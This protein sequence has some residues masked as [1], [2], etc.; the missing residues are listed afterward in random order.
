MNRNDEIDK[1]VESIMRE[2]T[3]NPRDY[4]FN[5]IVSRYPKTSHETF[6]FPGKF[7]KSLDRIV[8]KEDG[9]KLELDIAE[10]VEKDGFIT[11]KSTINVEHQTTPIEYGKIDP[12]YDYKIHL[13]H[14]NNLPSISIVITPIEQDEK[15]K[16]YTSKNNV[17]NVYHIVVREKD[18]CEKLNILRNIDMNIEISESN[19]INFAYIALFVTGDIDKKILEEICNMFAQVKMD[20]HHRLDTHHVLKI[21]IKEIFKDNKQKTKELL[22]MITKRLDEKEFCELTREE[23]FK[24]D[25]ARKDE[26]IENREYML[27]KEK[28]ETR[29]KLAEKDEETKKKLAEKERML[30]EQ[31]EKMKKLEQQI[32]QQNSK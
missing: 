7:I 13:I 9:S 6:G 1:M 11:Q 26:I 23:Q 22:K 3:N 5:Y 25:I 28:E 14:E 18:I 24:A 27:A 16:C 4:C 30:A 20:S 32:I 21:M 19:A 10:L 12:I 15:M 31:N 29:K 2:T 17:F 8:Y